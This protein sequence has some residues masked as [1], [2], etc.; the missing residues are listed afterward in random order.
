[1][2]TQNLYTLKDGQLTHF[3]LN[4][5]YIQ[6]ATNNADKTWHDSKVDLQKLSGECY[7]VFY[8]NYKT[9][10]TEKEFFSSLTQ[11]R[12]HWK[13]LVSKYKLQ[14]LKNV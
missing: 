12:K 13:K 6:R 10:E 14:V 9:Y 11:A 2:A 1:M 8:M 4:C 3:A 5:G 7:E